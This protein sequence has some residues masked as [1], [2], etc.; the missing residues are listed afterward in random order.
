MGE[1]HVDKGRWQEQERDLALGDGL[2]HAAQVRL[3]HHDRAA[4]ELT[5]R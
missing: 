5:H 4:A 2:D 1:Q 3:R